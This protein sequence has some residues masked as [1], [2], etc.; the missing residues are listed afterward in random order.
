AIHTK[1]R[2]D[3]KLRDVVS[4]GATVSELL[5][6][7]GIAV[8]PNDYVVPDPSRKPVDG[9]WIRVVRVQ[10]VITE[11]QVAIPF[12]NVTERDSQLASGTRRVVRSG[13][14]G[15]ELRKTLTVIEDGRQVSSQVVSVKTL[16]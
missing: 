9:M 8:G 15:L 7:A 12:D 14:E 5:T 6:Q 16:R 2:V 1:V 11:T 13:S 10:R 3:G 4:A